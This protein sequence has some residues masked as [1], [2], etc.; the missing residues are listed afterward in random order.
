MFDKNEE[1]HVVFSSSLFEEG[2][3]IYRVGR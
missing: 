2:G 3:P 1:N